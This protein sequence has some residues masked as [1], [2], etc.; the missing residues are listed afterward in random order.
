[1]AHGIEA[2]H[3]AGLGFQGIDREGL[4]AAPAGMGHMVGATPYGAT[5]PGV[6]QVEHQ[7]HVD[8]DQ[9]VQRGGRLPGPVAHPAHVFAVPAGGAQGHPAAV[10]GHHVAALGEPGGLD[11]Q[12][13]DRGVHVAGGAETGGFLAQHMPGLDR[14]AQL[15]LDI[16]QLHPPVV[17]KAELLEGRQP[18][19]LERVAV[20]LQV[21]HHEFHVLPDVV[22]QHETVVQF[23]APAH[24]WLVV[25]LAPE[26]GHQGAQ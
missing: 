2:V 22:R 17:G 21:L 23:G 12:A 8:A 9:R 4:V 1:M 15:Q 19:Q 14:P 5:V 26:A 18:L 6:D 25:G 3:A 20:G 7:G 24:Q 13:L 16:I 10:A 11:L